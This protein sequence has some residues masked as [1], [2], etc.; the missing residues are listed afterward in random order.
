MTDY[1]DADLINRIEER[2]DEKPLR[3]KVNAGLRGGLAPDSA[4]EFAFLAHL[5]TSGGGCGWSPI[6]MR[7]LPLWKSR[8]DIW[9]TWETGA[10]GL[11]TQKHT[12]R[13]RKKILA[14]AGSCQLLPPR[15]Q[16]RTRRN[17]TLF[18]GR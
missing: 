6:P 8:L 18:V 1:S 4:S 11:S 7:S 3:R 10:R 14:K 12:T 2:Q 5:A 17:V 15:L 13:P 9:S 16:E